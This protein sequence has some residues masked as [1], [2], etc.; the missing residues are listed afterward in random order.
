MIKRLLAI[1]VC[2]FAVLFLIVAMITV[3]LIWIV[4]G[5]NYEGKVVKMFLRL[6]EWDE[7]KTRR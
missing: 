3:L 6:V 4:S 2:L 1:P 5:K 7:N